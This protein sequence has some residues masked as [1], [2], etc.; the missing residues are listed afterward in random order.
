MRM[1]FE[2]SEFKGYYA[3]K[4]KALELG[5]LYGSMQRDDPIAVVKNEPGVEHP[6]KWV[7]MGT[8][9]KKTMAGMIVGRKRDG[10]VTL[11][12]FDG[13]DKNPFCKTSAPAI[14]G[15][16]KGTNLN[17]EGIGLN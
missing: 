3:A 2:G 8:P 16:I 12:I 4:A 10:P 7:H 11:I 14:Q 15:E 17:Y 6:P 9:S 5:M 13:F 1:R